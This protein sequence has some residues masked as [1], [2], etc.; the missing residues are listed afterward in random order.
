[1]DGNVGSNG[2]QAGLFQGGV[3]VN[4]VDELVRSLSAA[5]RSQILEWLD[6]VVQ[7]TA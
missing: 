2:S 7:Q 1:M 4:D 6:D 3:T 5:A